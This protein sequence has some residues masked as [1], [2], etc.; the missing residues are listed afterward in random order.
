MFVDAEGDA[1]ADLD[2]RVV[3]WQAAIDPGATRIYAV[4]LILPREAGG[5][6]LLPT[7][8]VRQLYTGTEAWIHG[9]ADVQTRMD[10]SRPERWESE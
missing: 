1:T 8:R 6:T 10:P 4:R 2:A 9:E 5:E 7:M 3:S